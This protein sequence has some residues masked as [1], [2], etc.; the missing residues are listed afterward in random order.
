MG[1]SDA[2][3]WLIITGLSER[4]ESSTAWRCAAAVASAEAD[5]VSM[6]LE[7]VLSVDVLVSD[8]VL[9][10]EEVLVSSEVEVLLVGSDVEE[11]DEE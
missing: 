2:E 10:V 3:K 7:L 8:G 1:V 9:S 5:D 6:L 4:L 11:E